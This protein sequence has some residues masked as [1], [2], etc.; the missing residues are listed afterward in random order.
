MTEKITLTVYRDAD[1]PGAYTWSPF[2]AKL[3]AH[4]RFCQQPYT[5]KVGSL[6][7][8][9]KGKLPY[10]RI[11]DKNGAQVMSDSSLI[12]RSLVERGM[13][14]LN[15]NL[16]PKERGLDLAI[17]ALLEDRIYYYTVCIPPLSL[18]LFLNRC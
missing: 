12:A 15:S 9:P 18:S 6:S 17:R 13:E 14:D 8:S 3:E 2:V 4:L 7:E 11:E 5:V 10:V 1:L 16:G